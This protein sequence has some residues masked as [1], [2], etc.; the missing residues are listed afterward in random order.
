MAIPS[1]FLAVTGAGPGELIS[2]VLL[3]RRDVTA[4]QPENTLVIKIM[5]FE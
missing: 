3:A 5:V 4:T 1:L 2:R